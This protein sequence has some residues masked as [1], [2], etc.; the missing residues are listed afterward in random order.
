MS[1]SPRPPETRDMGP[2]SHWLGH[3]LKAFSEATTIHG[4]TYIFSSSLPR[5]DRTLWALFTLASLSL[6]VFWSTT[7][8]TDWQNNLTITTLKDAA[9]PVTGITFPAV[10]V[11]TGGLDMEAVKKALYKD[12]TSW[13]QNKTEGLSEIEL[14]DE[15]MAVK[16]AVHQDR[17][18]FD[19]I[20]SFTSP[21]AKKSSISTAALQDLV[22]CGKK[23][24]IKKRR[25]RS[26]SAP[27]ETKF[28]FHHETGYSYYSVAVAAG[29]NMTADNVV[30]ACTIV[31]M[32]PIVA[33]G[34]LDS[35][36][37][38]YANPPQISTSLEYIAEQICGSGKSPSE[39]GLGNSFL[40]VAPDVY[41]DC[42]G[43]ARGTANKPC[44][45]DHTSTDSQPL[46]AAC[47]ATPGKYETE[48]WF[49]ISLSISVGVAYDKSAYYR[50]PVSPGL[51]MTRDTVRDACV[52]AGMEPLCTRPDPDYQYNSE[53]CSVST[54]LGAPADNVWRLASL[55]C[56]HKTKPSN[57]PDLDG[58]FFYMD[59][60]NGG[61]S[62]SRVLKTNNFGENLD[63]ALGSR[64]VS[65]ERTKPYYAAC[66]KEGGEY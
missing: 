32:K 27:T 15:Y 12:F 34:D 50:V 16:Y 58:V 36:R 24:D 6:G 35:L 1:L 31:D 55:L 64:Y 43:G 20:R 44:G 10:T 57:C 28:L 19:I 37:A 63:W 61:S 7:A 51:N 65:G 8:F 62:S 22:L 23:S 13:K 39:C 21:D 52:A 11:C 60:F 46:Y 18:I 66:V 17:N 14:L 9:K 54:N 3:T 30:E 41:T 4:I 49:S 53:E 38:E 42:P 29:L 33:N 26:T 25:K 45:N 56:E 5:A 40:Y 59:N 2:R 48:K 47:V